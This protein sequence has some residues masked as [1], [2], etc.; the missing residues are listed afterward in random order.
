MNSGI[1]VTGLI[2][3]PSVTL[4]T[5]DVGVFNPWTDTITIEGTKYSGVL[6]REFGFH[7]Q[8]GRIL[9][10][11][12]HADG[13]LTVGVLTVEQVENVTPNPWRETVLDQLASY[14]LDAPI[15]MAPA[16]VLAKVIDMAITIAVDPRLGNPPL[17]GAAAVHAMAK[18]LLDMAE[19]AGQVVTIENH[20][21]TP[22]AMG[23]YVPVVTVR[24]KRT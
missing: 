9:K 8:A 2:T 4:P 18:R 12:L 16:D 13:V 15:D 6:F 14:A 22:L 11:L 21:V 20:S 3:A 10:I 24:E 7:A 17:D 19:S 1:P 23:N 5:L